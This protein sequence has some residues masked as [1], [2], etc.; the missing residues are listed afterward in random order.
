VILNADYAEVALANLTQVTA[1]PIFQDVTPTTAWEQHGAGKDDMVI[2]DA[3]G[4]LVT[5]LAIDGDRAIE[6]GEPEGFDN[7][8]QAL[9]A[10]GK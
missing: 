2:Y 6:L 5:F 8:L 4:K 1:V 3:S 9:I 7:V 10:A